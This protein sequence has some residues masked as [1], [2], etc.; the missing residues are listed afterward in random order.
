MLLGVMLDGRHRHHIQ[1]VS[2]GSAERIIDN[3]LTNTKNYGLGEELDSLNCKRC[4]IV[5]NG[6]ILYN[7]SLGSRID[8]Y[9]VVVR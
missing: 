8:E 3:I 7:K 9:D 5:G 6:G 2:C 1:T 4:I